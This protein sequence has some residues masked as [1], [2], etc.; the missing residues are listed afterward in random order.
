MAAARW[1]VAVARVIQDIR[2]IL[3]TS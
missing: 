3:R 2:T 1:A